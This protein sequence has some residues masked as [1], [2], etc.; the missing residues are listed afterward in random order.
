[1][2][3]NIIY[4]YPLIIFIFLVN[5]HFYS[6]YQKNFL[7]IRRI[8]KNQREKSLYEKIQSQNHYF[9]I[10]Q[11][12]QKTN[13]VIFINED[14][15]SNFIDYVT[16][17]FKNK[18]NKTKPLTYYLTEL[19]LMIKYF[20]Y[21]RPIPVYSF[22]QI[23]I[24]PSLIKK[25]D[26]IIS[27][28]EFEDFYKK[29]IEEKNCFCEKNQ[30]EIMIEKNFLFIFNRLKRLDISAKHYVSMIKRP[31]KPYYIYQVIK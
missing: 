4:F 25:D 10:W 18:E 22:Y 16:T 30:E 12:L 8:I 19:G 17:Y 24:N 3:R 31:E 7:S 15:D 2:R 6:F 9:E 23:L 29:R 26:F 27:D 20:S 5:Y 28:Y 21:P 1:M 13:Q 11:L 14:K